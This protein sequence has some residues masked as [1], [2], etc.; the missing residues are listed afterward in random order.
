M[1]RR[2]SEKAL[3]PGYDAAVAP[4]RSSSSKTGN[5]EAGQAPSR[6][7]KPAD[8]ARRRSKKEIKAAEAKAAAARARRSR[9]TPPS[10]KKAPASKLWVPVTMFTMMIAGILVIA[11]NYLEV[12]PGKEATNS[13]LLIGLG[14]ITG[15]FMLSTRLR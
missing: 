1:W 2:A 13:F 4:S 11:G 3:A 10:P 5:A 8:K 9:Y 12:L 15:G 6:T 14:L 7:A